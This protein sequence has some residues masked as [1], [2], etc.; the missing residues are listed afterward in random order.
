VNFCRSANKE[1]IHG[2]W[3][4]LRFTKSILCFLPLGATAQG[5]LWPP[6]QSDSILLYSEAD[7]LVSEQFSFHG[8]ILLTSRP[9]HN[10]E[11]QG[12]PLRLAPIPWLVRHRWLYQSLRYRRHSTQ[13]LRSTQTPPPR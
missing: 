11:D 8:V 1:K 13:G 6:E 3:W 10:L 2:P 7:C 9:T 12:I 4:I 5:E